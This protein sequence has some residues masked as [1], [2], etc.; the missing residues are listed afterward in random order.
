MIERSITVDGQRYVF[1]L[2]PYPD[3]PKMQVHAPGVAPFDVESVDEA[4]DV[5]RSVY[6]KGVSQ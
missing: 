5:L 4:R 6:A 3:G 2:H 1:E